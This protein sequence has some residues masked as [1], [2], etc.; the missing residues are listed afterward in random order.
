MTGT[1]P[2]DGAPAPARVGFG[3]AAIGGL[4]RAVSEDRAAAT[5]ATAREA[6]IRHYDTA[7]HFEVGLSEPRAGLLPAHEVPG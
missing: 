6:G 7:P 2:S 1:R 5:L 4:F 3:A